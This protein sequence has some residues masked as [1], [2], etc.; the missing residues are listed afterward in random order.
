MFNGQD[1]R[2]AVFAPDLVD[3]LEH[4]PAGGVLAVYSQDAVSGLDPC[5]FGRRVRQRSGDDHTFTVGSGLDL[6]TNTAKLTLE[7]GLVDLER[8]WRDVG[9]VTV[10][11]SVQHTD[12]GGLGQHI[13]VDFFSGDVLSDQY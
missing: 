10:F 11:E 9:R 6:G 1:Y 13:R 5:L 8:F 4:G 12:D 7:S 3:S 2:G